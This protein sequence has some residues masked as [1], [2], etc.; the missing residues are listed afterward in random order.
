MTKKLTSIIILAF[1]L[2]LSGCKKKLFDYRNKFLGDYSITYHYSYW[3]MGGNTGDTTIQYNGVIE[4]GDKGNIKL[5]WYNGDRYEFSV[6][7]KGTISKCN[8]TIG[9][10]S[11]KGFDLSFTDDLCGTG[12]MSLNYTITLHG[13]EK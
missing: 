5:E 4:Y 12:P 10:I 9:N 6:S 2:S 8:S 1:I 3:Q 7:K 11:K 13:D